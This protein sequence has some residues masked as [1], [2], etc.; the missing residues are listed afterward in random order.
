MCS[1]VCVCAVRQRTGQQAQVQQSPGAPL[2]RTQWACAN[3]EGQTGKWRGIGI[4]E[5]TC[6]APALSAH[7]TLIM[8][9]T[10]VNTHTHT[11]QWKSQK[12]RTHISLRVTSAVLVRETDQRRLKVNRRDKVIVFYQ[13]TLRSPNIFVPLQLFCHFLPALPA[14]PCSPAD[15]FS[16]C[17]IRQRIRD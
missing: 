3:M 15:F 7:D 17:V 1:S 6:W 11:R 13:E 5:H 14:I 8:D 9:A 12:L 2:W 10:V 16:L 4:R